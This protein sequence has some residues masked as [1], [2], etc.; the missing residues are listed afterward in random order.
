M[1]YNADVDDFCINSMTYKGKQYGLTYYTDYMGFLL[2][3]RDPRE[4]RHQR[5]ADHLGG[6]ARTVPS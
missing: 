2:R 4:S 6:S 3:R 5:S 1:K